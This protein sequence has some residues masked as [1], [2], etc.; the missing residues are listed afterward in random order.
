MYPF[1]RGRNVLFVKKISPHLLSIGDVMVFKNSYDSSNYIVHRLIKKI[2]IRGNEFLFQ[3]KG[4]ATIVADKP[5]YYENIIGKVYF[6][7]KDSIWGSKKLFNLDS[8]HMKKINYL[9]AKTSCF[10]VLYFLVMPI[11][12]CKYFCYK[13]YELFFN[14]N[15]V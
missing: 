4:D 6:I 2:H 8:W 5:V 9:L 14:K 15:V 11:R 7:E 12:L 1:L 3:T 10:R 13:L